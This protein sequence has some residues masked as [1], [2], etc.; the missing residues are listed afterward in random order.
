MAQDYKYTVQLDLTLERGK[1]LLQ[2]YRL[3]AQFSKGIENAR[4]VVACMHSPA[5]SGHATTMMR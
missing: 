2:N 5:H 3:P 4:L 1:C